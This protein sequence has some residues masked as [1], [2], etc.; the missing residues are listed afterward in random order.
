M[1]ILSVDDSSVMRKVIRGAVDVLGY[2]FLEASNGQEA[3]DLLYQ[4]PDVNLVLLDWNM[5]I[6]DGL[7]TLK[8]IKAHASLS[9][10]PVMMVTTEAESAHIV[11]AIQAGACNYLVKPFTHEDLTIRIIQ[12]LE[13]SSA[14]N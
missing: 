12:S 10:I 4:T 2:D 3:L 14:L 7:Q 9:D 1:K 8:A 11:D 6:L 5:P 13:S